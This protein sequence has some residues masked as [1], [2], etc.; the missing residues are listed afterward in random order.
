MGNVL[1]KIQDRLNSQLGPGGG[2]S[3]A[4]RSLRKSSGCSDF[5][6]PLPDPEAVSPDGTSPEQLSQQKR[7]NCIFVVREINSWDDREA[8]VS[9][10]WFGGGIMAAIGRLDKMD[11][12]Y[13][14]P[15][16]P[17]LSSAK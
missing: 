16:T 15:T 6:S 11:V 10:V 13:R 3:C 14:H 17:S 1:N 7:A 2:S 8:G 9:V 12:L 4:S 5:T